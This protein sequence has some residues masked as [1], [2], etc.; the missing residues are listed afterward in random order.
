MI[1][2]GGTDR[3]LF[4]SDIHLDDHD[5]A[6]ARLFFEMLARE[7]PGAT[8]LFLLGD[9]F[10]AWVGDDDDSAVGQQLLHALARLSGFDRGGREVLPGERRS[11]I[12]PE[13]GCPCTTPGRCS[14]GSA[15]TRS[16]SCRSS[17]G[18]R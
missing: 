14:S 15:P 17:A 7:A 12:T 10:E 8:H 6:T 11:R 2:L 18:R 4:A 3:G 5:P 9:L 16:P 13:S 1:T